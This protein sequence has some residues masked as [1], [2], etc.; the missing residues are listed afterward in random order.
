MNEAQLEK[1]LA[2]LNSTLR[3]QCVDT[4]LVTIQQSFVPLLQNCLK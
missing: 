3:E 1:A 2:E 4:K